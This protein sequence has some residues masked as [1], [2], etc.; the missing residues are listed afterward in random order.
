LRTR[1]RTEASYKAKRDVLKG[2]SRADE[3]RPLTGM[4]YTILLFS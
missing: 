3:S 4:F 1:E 2:D